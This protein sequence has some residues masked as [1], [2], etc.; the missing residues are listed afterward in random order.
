MPS[1]PRA[2]VALAA[3]ALSGLFMPRRLASQNQLAGGSPAAEHG[4]TCLALG[5]SRSAVAAC[6]DAAR[7]QPADARFRVRLADA[8]AA[9]GDDLAALEAYGDAMRLAPDSAPAW[10]GAARILDRRGDRRGALQY[11]REFSRL[12]PHDAEGP[13]ISG[14]LLLELREPAS[15][16]AAFREASARDATSA[17]AAY[18]AGM[19]LLA[20]TRFSEA[21]HTLQ[22]AVRLGPGNA[23]AWGALARAAAADGRQRDAVAYWERARTIDGAYFDGRADERR[24]WQR[25]ARVTGPQ[26]PA[27]VQGSAQSA[28]LE[29]RT[30][31][32]PPRVPGVVPASRARATVFY[33]SG[34]TGTGFVVGS[35]G[36]VLTNRHVVRGCRAVRVRPEGGVARPATVVALD[37]DDDLALLRTDT[38][39]RTVAAF[40]GGR[41]PRAGEDVVA[42]GYPLAGLLADQAHVT[43]G[44]ISALAGLYN[45][46]HELTISTPVQPGNSGGP[47]LDSY[48]TVVGVVVMK[49]NARMVQETTGDLPQNVN[50]AIKG[51]VAR[52]FLTAQGVVPLTGLPV[53]TMSNAD[54]GDVGRSLSLLVECTK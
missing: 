31:T 20:L 19:A 28:T 7:A 22:G 35:R 53:T 33:A 14:W 24:Q 16:L 3:L 27:T 4:A 32:P 13:E 6:R 25:I 21:V 11:Y 29:A 10:F 12:T 37:P 45:D 44:S 49:L 40:R 41:E 36:Y 43:I 48:G 1:T 2:L 52:E 9:A 8:L 23:G 54:I 30:A 18:G 47:L 5:T 39:F 42:V 46:L 50:F 38:T 26:A 15:A 34:T 51:S 17:G